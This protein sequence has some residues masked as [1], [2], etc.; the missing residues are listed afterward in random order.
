MYVRR[1]AQA[2]QI[3]SP[4]QLGTLVRQMADSLG[5]TTPGM[6]CNR[7]RIDKP[8]AAQPAAVARSTRSSARDRFKVVDGDGA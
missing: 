6:R 3:E 4:M 5:I 7:W 2:E 8:A 1:F